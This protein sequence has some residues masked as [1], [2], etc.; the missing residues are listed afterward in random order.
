MHLGENDEGSGVWGVGPRDCPGALACL[1]GNEGVGLME[2]IVLA[3]RTQM[4]QKSRGR[5]AGRVS[6]SQTY[7]L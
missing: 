4:R 2:R 5:A 7:K 3:H 1:D 6:L